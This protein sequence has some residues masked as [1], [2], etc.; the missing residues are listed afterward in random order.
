MAGIGCKPPIFCQ[1]A[2]GGVTRTPQQTLR[3]P[4]EP[5]ALVFGLYMTVIEGRLL[6]TLTM[7]G[8]RGRPPM[9]CIKA[10]GGV[11]RGAPTN[12]TA[13][14]GASAGPGPSGPIAGLIIIIISSGPAA[15][16]KPAEHTGNIHGCVLNACAIISTMF[17]GS[18]AGQGNAVKQKCTCENYGKNNSNEY[19][20]QV[21]GLGAYV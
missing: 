20:V 6:T 16:P 19:T 4:G 18:L 10:P 8:M 5:L 21:Q 15:G 9:F 12:P 2:P 1:H 13:P 7:A 11:I 17:T 14:N 3:H